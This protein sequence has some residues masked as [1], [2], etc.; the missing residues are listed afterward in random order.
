MNAARTGV[1]KSTRADGSP[2][3]FTPAARI[4]SIVASNSSVGTYN[5]K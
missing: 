5:A 4:D 2:S 3:I 1:P